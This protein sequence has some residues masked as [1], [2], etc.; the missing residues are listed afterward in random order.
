MKDYFKEYENDFLKPEED[1]FEQFFDKI[2]ELFNY[3]KKKNIKGLPQIKINPDFY[4][5]DELEGINIPNIGEDSSKVFLKVSEAFEG[6]IKFH[7]PATLFNITPPPIIDTVV[8]SALVNLYNPNL[9]MDYTS[10]KIILFEKQV[11]KYLCDLV[12]FDYKLADGFSCFGGKATLIYAIKE[13]LNKCNRDVVKEGIKDNYVVFTA[14]SCHYTIESAC[15]YL[16][17]GHNACVR[18]ACDKE[19]NIIVSELEKKIDNAINENK[20]IAC[21]ILSGG[22]TLDINTDPIEEVCK[23]RDSIVKKYNLNYIPHIH[24]DTVIGWLW[25]FYKNYNFGENSLQL[26]KNVLTKIKNTTDRL[27][28]T[29]LA[30]SFSADFH[31][32]GFCPYISSFYVSKSAKSLQSLNSEE[33]SKIEDPKFGDYQIYQSSMENSRSGAGI[34]SAWVVMN[35]FGI[36]GFQKYL[37]YILTTSMYMRKKIEEIYGEHFEILNNFASGQCIMLRPKFTEVDIPFYTLL[38]ESQDKKKVYNDYCSD[39]YKY[40]SFYF[41]RA[42]NKKEYPLIGVLKNYRKRTLGSDLSALRLLSTS[43]YL[44]KNICDKILKM[45]VDIKLDF[46]KVRRSNFDDF[47]KFGMNEHQPH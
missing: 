10:G 8:V 34:L 46:E 6:L 28:A 37:A 23:L 30:D 11:I 20:K 7:D 39:F 43:V 5:S 13:G 41:C 32:T 12:G 17:L 2:K 36:L 21:I 29:E 3:I 18:I 22:G 42:E 26:E 4:Y 31:K 15:N 19:E 47:K 44:N 33:Y 1:N 35:R 14:K 38:N 40:I 27:R 9:L 16:G 25:F 24:I 45:I